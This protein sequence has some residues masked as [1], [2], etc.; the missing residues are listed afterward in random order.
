MFGVKKKFYITARL[1]QTMGVLP[2]IAGSM[3]PAWDL[4][5]VFFN[6]PWS[7]ASDNP[8]PLL[9]LEQVKGRL[10]HCAWQLLGLL[11]GLRAGHTLTCLGWG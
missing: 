10:E 2:S 6:A 9:Y 8:H 1:V 11:Q 7:G 5:S 3:A 4:P